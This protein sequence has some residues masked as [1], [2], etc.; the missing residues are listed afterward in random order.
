MPQT[1]GLP[2]PHGEIL[3][4]RESRVTDMTVYPTAEAALQAARG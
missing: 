3:T 4:F 2:P 1:N